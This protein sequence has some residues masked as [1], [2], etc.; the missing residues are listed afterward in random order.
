MSDASVI[1]NI[2]LPVFTPEEQTLIAAVR[3][4]IGHYI[5]SVMED[6]DC[7]RFLR[8]RKSDVALASTM[9]KNWYGTAFMASKL[10]VC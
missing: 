5:S 4:E 9:I 10:F 7:L 3:A 6:M 1:D 2:I 8:A